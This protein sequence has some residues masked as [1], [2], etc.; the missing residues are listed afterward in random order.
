MG[1]PLNAMQ[2]T[3]FVHSSWKKVLTCCFRIW[4]KTACS[5]TVDLKMYLGQGELM[6]NHWGSKKGQWKK[7][8]NSSHETIRPARIPLLLGITKYSGC[9]IF[10]AVVHQHQ[11]S[12]KESFFPH[13]IY[14]PD[15]TSTRRKAAQT[16][17]HHSLRTRPGQIGTILFLVPSTLT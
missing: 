4:K 13:C 12:S 3:I 6:Q 17:S 2:M 9:H 10:I 5:S 8:Y 15:C 7:E 1:S 14:A 16:W 11:F